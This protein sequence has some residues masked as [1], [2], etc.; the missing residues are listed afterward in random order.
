MN[1]FAWKGMTQSGTI[2]KGFIQ[3]ASIS[4]IQKILMGRHIA[5]LE[6]HPKRFTSTLF[7]EWHRIL[8]PKQQYEFFSNLA[9]LLTSGITLMA[10]LDLIQNQTP[11]K[12]A[13]S[14][15]ASLKASISQGAS[16]AD[17]LAQ[18]PKTFS[19]FT[20]QLID[21]GEQ[22]GHLP[23]VLEH[24]TQYL[25]ATLLLRSQIK[26]ALLMPLITLSFSLV[27]LWTI[28]IFV[29][30]HF[31]SLYQSLGCAIPPLTRTVLILSATLSSWWGFTLV[32]GLL[33][34]AFIVRQCTKH[35]TVRHSINTILLHIP[36]LKTVITGREVLRLLELLTLFIRA[37]I[38]LSLGLEQA[39][40]G[41]NIPEFKKHIAHTL[42]AITEGK[43]LSK[44]FEEI[45][46]PYFDAQLI[47]LIRVGEHAH[48]LDAMLTKAIAVSRHTLSGKLHT[49]SNIAAPLFM[50]CVGLL[51]GGLMALMYMPILNLGS[52]FSS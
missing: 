31:E 39:L 9:L 21:A 13:Q 29:I 25:E 35:P 32:L 47:A 28:L 34:L 14:L 10:A 37:G 1:W 6:A 5:L 16:F 17:S 8:S 7:D 42:N 45:G 19:P 24:L 52:L 46:L 50:V 12:K 49:I 48:S 41:T 23:T 2:T 22:T 38:P 3:A 15:F 26:R 4:D 11:S 51:I 44:A 30:P 43:S 20:M 33:P 27:L 18:F 40:E 36:Y